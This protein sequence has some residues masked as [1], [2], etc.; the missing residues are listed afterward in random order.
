MVLERDGYFNFPHANAIYD[1]GALNSAIPPGEWDPLPDTLNWRPA[2]GINPCAS[3]VHWHGPKP[4]HVERTIA[5]GAA[6]APD[7]TMRAMLE[8]APQAYQYYLEIFRAALR[9]AGS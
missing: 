4:R 6:S 8:A 7:E 9:C 1:Q 2:F 5:T 3:I